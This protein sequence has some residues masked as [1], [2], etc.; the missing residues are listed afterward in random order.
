MVRR[1]L[2]IGQAGLLNGRGLGSDDRRP[3]VAAGGGRRYPGPRRRP[4]PNL[5][6]RRSRRRLQ[7][8]QRGLELSGRR[9]DACPFRR[10]AMSVSRVPPPREEHLMTVQKSFKRLVR[11]RMDKTGESYTAARSHLLTAEEPAA[12][13]ETVLAT[14]DAKIRERT[15]RGWEE[16]FDLLD[17]WGAAGR[18]H[19]EIARW[20]AEQQGVVPLAWNA[21]AVVGSYER[22]RG[23][24][25]VGEHA[26]G[27][28]ITATRTG[29][30][31]VDGLYDAFVDAG[32][33]ECW[34]PDG[35]LSE[36]T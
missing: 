10:G 6:F 22:A 28:T 16:W 30:V 15:G 12:I 5:R 4:A 33:R 9:S 32:L 1:S 14:S 18:T 23:L 26:D 27:F 8:R 31:R 19:R 7:R 35:E 24:R 21:Q 29:G 20:V 17:D 25:A 36:R 34:L 3:G 2:L 11:A 13:D